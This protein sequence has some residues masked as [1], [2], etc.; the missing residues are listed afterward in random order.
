MELMSKLAARLSWTGFAN[1]RQRSILVLGMIFAV[2]LVVEIDRARDDRE[3]DVVRAVERSK[4]ETDSLSRKQADVLLAARLFLDVLVDTGAAARLLDERDCS[5]TMVSQLSLLPHA[6]NMILAL[7]SGAILCRADGRGDAVNVADRL[8][9][10]QSMAVD[11]TV[12]GVAAIDRLTGRW[13]LPVARAMLGEDGRPRAVLAVLID[14]GWVA[15]ELSAA[16][17]PPGTTLGLVDGRG[18]VL[19][20]HP[21]PG[22]ALGRSIAGSALFE[23]VTGDGAVDLEGADGVTR[24]IAR[25]RLAETAAGPVYLWAGLDRAVMTRDSD[26]QFAVAV[27]IILTLAF[28]GMMVALVSAEIF[29]V[30]PSRAIVQ[31]AQAIGGGDSRARTGVDHRSGELGQVAKAIDQMAFALTSKSEILRLNRALK[32]ITACHK[33]LVHAEDEHQMLVE[34]CR[35]IVEI[36][37]YRMAWVGYT[38][39]DEGRSVEPVAHFGHEEGYLDSIRISWGDNEFGRGPTGTAIRTGLP[40]VNRDFATNPLM[41]P[42]V[43]AALERGYRSSSAFPLIADGHAFGALTIYAP[44]VAP[45]NEE[46]IGLLQE[47]ASDLAFGVAM[48]GLRQSSQRARERLEKSLEATIAAVAATLELRDAYTAGHQRRVSKLAGAIAAKLGLPDDD[49]HGIRLA[50]SIH[51]IGKIQVPSEIL[52]KPTA[53]DEV[54]KLLLRRHPQAGFDILKGIDFPWPIAQLVRQHHEREDG[55]GYPQGLS[56][57][58]T[59]LGAKI[60]GVADVLEAMSSHRPYRPALGIDKALQELVKNRGRFYDPAV[61]D[62]CVALFRDD[63]FS[64]EG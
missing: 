39:D 5:A 8:Y 43:G 60:I 12:L 13:S 59:L 18:T 15:S 35:N 17:F 63:G 32:V 41:A 40:Q 1:L 29:V 33:S 64:F 20:E 61:V 30:R 31:A 52:V 25:S 42:W 57:A 16:G 3:A 2:I 46:E 27:A 11:G 54:E 55:S 23:A 6:E 47:L 14:L 19:A 53:L 62:A 49:I 28:G 56:G 48:L 38:R 10:E 24:V 22:L 58:Q 50:A 36:G 9:F 51:D 45:F 4:V 26:R 21:D 44:A 34:V 7:P 37:G